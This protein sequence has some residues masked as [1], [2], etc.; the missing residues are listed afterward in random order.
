MAS[1]CTKT[2]FLIFFISLH[3]KFEGGEIDIL[4]SE[5]VTCQLDVAKPRQTPEILNTN[6][7]DQRD[8]TE[9]T[10]TGPSNRDQAEE[11]MEKEDERK[12]RLKKSG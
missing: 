8:Q 2:K 12:M 11:M 1:N 3:H 4:S 6:L 9:K 10:W 5:P 7:P